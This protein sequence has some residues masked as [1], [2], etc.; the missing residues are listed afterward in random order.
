M[1]DKPIRTEKHEFA[2]NTLPE[3]LWPV[4]DE[5]VEHYKFA[6]SLHHGSPFVSY[7]VLAEMVKAGWRPTGEPMDHWKDN[8]KANDDANQ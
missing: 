5:F 6:A 8:E 3:D 4:F 2:R 1:K 7:I